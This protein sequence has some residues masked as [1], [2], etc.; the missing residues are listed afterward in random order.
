MKLSSLLTSTIV[1]LLIS[2]CTASV[3]GVGGNIGGGQQYYSPYAASDEGTAVVYIYWNQNDIERYIPF[4][5]RKPTWNTYVNR[6]RNAELD[7]GSY[8]V[9][10]VNPG[11]VSI[12]ART[13]IGSDPNISDRSAHIGLSAKAGETYY[14]SARLG[15]GNLGLELVL[16]REISEREAYNHLYGLRYQKNLQDTMVY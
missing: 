8:S 15:Q 3:N 11:R 14:I 2:G 7:E 9:V 4:G 10:E 5:N 6:K 12:E 16:D 13:R 1:L